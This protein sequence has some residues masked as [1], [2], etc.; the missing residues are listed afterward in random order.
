MDI[1]DPHDPLVIDINHLLVKNIAA[2]GKIT[3]RYLVGKFDA[4]AYHLEAD[5]FCNVDDIIPI[6][7][8]IFPTEG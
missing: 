2:E 6:D 3:F 5:L 4:V 7:L 1:I 8:G